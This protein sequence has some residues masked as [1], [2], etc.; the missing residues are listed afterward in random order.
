MSDPEGRLLNP[1]DARVFRI[2]HIDNVPW[3]FDHGLHC[4][5]AAVRDPNFVPIGM[6]GLIDKR[7]THPVPIS[8]GGVLAD[9]VPFYFTPWSM[10][11]LNIHTGYNGVVRRRNDEIVILVGQL[12]VFAARGLG[13]VFTDGHAY[14]T[15]TQK[16]YFNDL[17]RLDQVDWAIL[18]AR[19]FARDPADP[20]KSRRYQAE[21]LV[22]SHVPVDAL[23]GIVCNSAVGKARIDHWLADRGRQMP[24]AVRPRWYF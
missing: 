8:P 3:L 13:V 5:S 9:Y 12:P 11:L 20:D 16:H 6:A 15:Q 10:M 23:S 19:N 21:A 14:M 18:R 24:V 17:A 22:R 4:Q 7:R 2:T 1:H